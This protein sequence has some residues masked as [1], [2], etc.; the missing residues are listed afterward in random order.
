MLGKEPNPWSCSRPRHT[1]MS[2]RGNVDCRFW[3]LDRLELDR[4]AD[5]RTGPSRQNRHN[6]R[7]PLESKETLSHELLYQYP[8][9]YG[10]HDGTSS[11]SL[12]Y[13][14]GRPV[15]LQGQ[16]TGT[17]Y[18]F[19]GVEREQF[20]HPRDAVSFVTDRHFRVMAVV[21]LSVSPS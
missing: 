20:V 16:A 13:S 17:S 8:Y 1:R 12:A 15:I 2:A 18:R 6:D 21:E 4:V 10:S 14:G 9:Q 3:G 5:N 19:S 7:P 11:R